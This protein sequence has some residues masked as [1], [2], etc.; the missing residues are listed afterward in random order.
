VARSSR[1]RAGRA[2]GL[3]GRRKRWQDFV[4]DLLHG[5]PPDYSLAVP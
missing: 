3:L 5:E 4:P 1:R 2:G